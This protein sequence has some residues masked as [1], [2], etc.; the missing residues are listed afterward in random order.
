VA[1]VVPAIS[2]G[3]LEAR[4]AR[5]WR[6]P[7]SEWLGGWLLRAADGFTGRANSALAVG[8]P[9]RPLDEAVAQVCAWYGARGLP[10]MVAVPFPVS[11]PAASPVDRLLAEQG[12]LLRQRP[13]VV[14]T[15]ATAV[16]ARAAAGHDPAEIRV[17]AE[18]DKEW[19]ERYHYRGQELAPVAVTLLTSAPWQAFASVREAGQTVAVGRVAGADGWAG[20][21]AIE[22]DP[23]RR[24][25]GLGTIVTAALAGLAA[26][27]GAAG[28]Y[29]QVE[30]G[31]DAA[32][33]LYA[34]MGF[35]DH[36]RYHYRLAPEA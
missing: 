5:D 12:W 23:A 18:P 19:L 24:R 22:T 6:A 13:A 1:A 2:V 27:H 35:T 30:A 34:G 4:A 32:R 26:E 31:N 20:L 36:H 10:P 28:L 8:D 3:Q 15:A 14:M 29:L 7:D 17:A 33:A 11:G 16:I 21:A 25:R 9:G